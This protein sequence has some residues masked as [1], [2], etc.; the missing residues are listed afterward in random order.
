MGFDI[1]GFFGAEDS[2]NLWVE[3][4]LPHPLQRYIPPI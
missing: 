1:G 4:G 2:L 3:V